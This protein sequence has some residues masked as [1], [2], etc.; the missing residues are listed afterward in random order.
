[1]G[2]I[3]A[4]IDF[5]IKSADLLNENGVGVHTTEFNVYSD[6]HTIIEGPNVVIENLIFVRFLNCLKKMDL[7]WKILTS[8]RAIINTISKSMS[9]HIWGQESDI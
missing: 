2:N 7:H 1:L 6:V 8:I 4:G 5:I 9:L 3:Q